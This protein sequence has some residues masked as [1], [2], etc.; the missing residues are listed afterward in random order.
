MEDKN[1]GF[2]SEDRCKVVSVTL[3]GVKLSSTV[4]THLKMIIVAR[5]RKVGRS[6]EVLGHTNAFYKSSRSCCWD[7]R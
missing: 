3:S 6:S 7:G 1:T 2:D 4:G 5:R